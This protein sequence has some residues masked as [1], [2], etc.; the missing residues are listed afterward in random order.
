MSSA[1]NA[2]VV[3]GVCRT[4]ALSRPRLPAL[5]VGALARRSHIIEWAGGASELPL[6]AAPKRS[7]ERLVGGGSVKSKTSRQPARR[8]ART[9]IGVNGMNGD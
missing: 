6:V 3:A 8:V 1:L 2:P 5:Q 7:L 9:A 4:M